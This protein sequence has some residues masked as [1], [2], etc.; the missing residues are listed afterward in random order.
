MLHPDY[1]GLER[2]VDDAMEAVY[3]AALSAGATPRQI[4]EQ[5]AATVG[6]I[7]HTMLMLG[8][9]PASR[10]FEVFL[11]GWLLSLAEASYVNV[12][13]V[14]VAFLMRRLRDN[15]TFGPEDDLVA[16]FRDQLRDIQPPI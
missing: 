3:T 15:G 9:D 11:Y 10:E 13:Q 1:E 14:A 2:E 6:E 5:D 12:R 16:R 8:I 7:R 4:L